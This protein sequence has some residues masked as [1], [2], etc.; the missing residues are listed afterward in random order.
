MAKYFIVLLIC[1]A[2]GMAGAGVVAEYSAEGAGDIDPTLQGWEGLEVLIDD[3]S[4]GGNVSPVQPDG[5]TGLNA[6]QINDIY[7]SSGTANSSLDG[8]L[9]R[10]MMSNSDFASMYEYGWEF[11]IIVRPV[12]GSVG[13]GFVGWGVNA[14]VTDFEDPGWGLG[15]RERVG[16]GINYIAESNACQI[17]PTHGGVRAELCRWN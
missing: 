6:W 15:T 5:A 2:A 7:G 4:N 3:G 8:P 16:F 9:Y 1:V 17:S 12:F 13:C 14:A 10:V 11:T